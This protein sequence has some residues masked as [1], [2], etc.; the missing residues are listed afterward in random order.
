MEPEPGGQ[1]ATEEHRRTEKT[2]QEVSRGRMY[3]IDIT[4]MDANSVLELR[5]LLRDLDD[6][7]AE[8]KRG[9]LK[10]PVK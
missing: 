9:V 1:T 3:R 2:I 10:S 6:R 4:G 8:L 7:N 5:R